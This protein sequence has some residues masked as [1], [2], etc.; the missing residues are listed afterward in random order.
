MKQTAEV[1]AMM[2]VTLKGVKVTVAVAVVDSVSHVDS[3]DLII[4]ILCYSLSLHEFRQ[5]LFTY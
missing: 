5:S 3:N 2:T 4:Q 1:T